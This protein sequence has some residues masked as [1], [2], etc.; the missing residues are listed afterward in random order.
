MAAFGEI[1]IGSSAFDEND[2]EDNTETIYV[3][4]ENEIQFK[5]R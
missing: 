5:I 2:Y 1:D 3:T 4:E